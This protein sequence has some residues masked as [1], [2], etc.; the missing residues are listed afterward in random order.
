MA[1]N[2]TVNVLFFEWDNHFQSYYT[3]AL[4]GLLLKNDFFTNY[5]YFV[6]NDFHYQVCNQDS[7]YFS[8]R[9]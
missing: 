1:L 2:N 6:I 3:W 4:L 9:A 7:L 8:F 5:S